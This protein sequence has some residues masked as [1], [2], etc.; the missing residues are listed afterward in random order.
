MADE[1]RPASQIDG[2]QTTARPDTGLAQEMAAAM[3]KCIENASAETMAQVTPANA[4]INVNLHMGYWEVRK[5]AN[6]VLVKSPFR[7]CV[8]VPM[9]KEPPQMMNPNPVFATDLEVPHFTGEK[10]EVYPQ[11]TLFFNEILFS[12]AQE[13]LSISVLG[14]KERSGIPQNYPI[15]V[16]DPLGKKAFTSICKLIE[17]LK[18]DG[19]DYHKL[20][21][22]LADDLVQVG[23]TNVAGPHPVYLKNVSISCL[24]LYFSFT[25]LR[26]IGNDGSRAVLHNVLTDNQSVVFNFLC[27]VGNKP[28]KEIVLDYFGNNGP[29]LL[30]AIGKKLLI[31]TELRKFQ[32]DSSISDESLQTV[33]KNDH[34]LQRALNQDRLVSGYD[35]V[36][37]EIIILG[38]RR[39]NTFLFK[40]ADLLKAT[41]PLD[42]IQQVIESDDMKFTEDFTFEFDLRRV[43]EVSLDYLQTIVWMKNTFLTDRS[44][45]KLLKQLSISSIK[46]CARMLYK[47]RSADLIPVNLRSYYPD[48]LKP[49]KKWKTGKE[50]HDK[51]SKDHTDI[52]AEASNRPI[53]HRKSIETLHEMTKDGLKIVLPYETKNLVHWGKTLKICVASY[54]DMAASNNVY[55]AC[56]Y[57]DNLPC[58]MLEYKP[59]TIENDLPKFVQFKAESNTLVPAEDEKIVKQM[60]KE[61]YDNHWKEF[62]DEKVLTE[63]FESG[64]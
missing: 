59:E 6:T 3:G 34:A 61:W 56:I 23:Q 37:R 5:N 64:D 63:G 26:E 46:D 13:G 4:P 41:L 22:G 12:F 32:I 7:M 43:R 49:P 54:A 45:V 27:R 62:L 29:K 55:L 2:A 48:G 21:C 60:M 14:W 11:E 57:K 38:E 47:Y 28:F 40:T 31:G 36:T 8:S 18:K 35:P 1:F 58:Y 53:K 16:T 15:N 9:E 42:I 33:F 10:E 17:S 52:E 20:Y 51:I 30:K 44:F 24:L 50:F 39:I 19:E 25:L